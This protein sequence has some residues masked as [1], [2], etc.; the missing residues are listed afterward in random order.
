MII[1]KSY[2]ETY[3]GIPFNPIEPASWDISIIDIA[4]ALSNLCRYNGHCKKF[5]SVA[6][7]SVLVSRSLPNNQK[8]KLWGLLHDAAEA[9]L[10][11][12]PKPVKHQLPDFIIKENKFLESVAERYKLPI[13]IPKEVQEADLRIL[14]NEKEDVMESIHIW[15]LI[16]VIDPLP[17]IKIKCLSPKKAKKLF[18]DTYIKIVKEK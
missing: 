1:S 17:N 18:L 10:G 11:D 16:D 14:V 2:I 12:I 15:P 9:Y 5:Y 7:H 4:H 8:L 3:S 13:G 6:E